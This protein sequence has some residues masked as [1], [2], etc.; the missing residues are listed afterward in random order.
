MLA[1]SPPQSALTPANFTTLPHC[2]VSSTMSLPKSLG[3][4]VSAMPPRSA[5][6]AFILESATPASISLLSLSI[7]STGVFLGASGA[8]HRRQV[9]TP[10]VGYWAAVLSR[11]GQDLRRIEKTLGNRQGPA[12]DD[13]RE[14]MRGRAWSAAETGRALG[15]PGL[16]CKPRIEIE[17]SFAAQLHVALRAL[18][19][20]V[21]AMKKGQYIQT[22]F[23]VCA[24]CGKRHAKTYKF[25]FLAEYGVKGKYAA[26]ECLGKLPTPDLTNVTFLGPSLTA[27]ESDPD[28]YPSAG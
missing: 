26:M 21:R 17:E 20:Y 25:P 1:P 23:Q 24:L 7:I 22:H 19:V 15:E 9:V 12:R 8:A 14:P 3:E 27:E 11:L 2:S 28:Y 13:V 10:Q 6:R 5:S 18:R 4:P 16:R